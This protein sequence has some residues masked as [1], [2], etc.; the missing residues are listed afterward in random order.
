MLCVFNSDILASRTILFLCFNRRTEQLSYC[1]GSLNDKLTP[2]E[3][4]AAVSDLGLAPR[5]TFVCG[6]VGSDSI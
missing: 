4:C 1:I 2:Q 5:G 6:A 3:G